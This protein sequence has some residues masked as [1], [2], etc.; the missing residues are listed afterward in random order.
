MDNPILWQALFGLFAIAAIAFCVLGAQVWRIPTVLTVVGLFLG[1]ATFFVL[2]ALTLRTHAYW[3]TTYLQQQKDLADAEEEHLKLMQGD[4]NASDPA[5]EMPVGEEGVEG[6]PADAPT[7]VASA[8]AESNLLQMGNR[9]LRKELGAIREDRG[10]TWLG[11]GTLAL[12]NATVTITSPGAGL[13][14][15]NMPVYVFEKKEG[16]MFLGEF[17]VTEAAGDAIK[18]ALTETITPEQQQAIAG[19]NG[20]WIVRSIMPVD[21]HEAFRGLPKEELTKLIPQAATGLDA[22]AYDALINEYVR[23]G[24]PA[25]PTDPADRVFKRV[26]MTK[27]TALEFTNEKGE[28]ITQNM[29]SDDELLVS[30]EKAQELV[31]KHEAEI[32][33]PTGI[34]VRPLRNYENTRRALNLR[35][36]EL[37]DRGVQVRAQ[38]AAVEAST[39]SANEIRM[40]S[41]TKEET[42][43]KADL[44]KMNHDRDVIKKYLDDLK[45]Q[46]TDLLAALTKQFKDNNALADQLTKLQIDLAKKID[47]QAAAKGGAN[48]VPVS[49]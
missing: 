42:G 12:P 22:A 9:R 18:L 13:I 14:V 21:T 4:S 25:K 39:K 24:Q 32:V 29:Q 2:A 26:K 17:K 1:A 44:E 20:E 45:A 19:K 48:V 8:E 15:A 5:A 7:T 49:R 40:V 37:V 38:T 46:Q 6:E 43:L 31:T 30:S 3:R 16:G 35:M 23:D 33:D 36:F 28:K 10:K 47:A 34:Y 27:E 41:L 11:N